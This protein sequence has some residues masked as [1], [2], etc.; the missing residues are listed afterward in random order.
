MYSGA[1]V[2]P[3]TVTYQDVEY[4]VSGFDQTDGL[5]PFV[6]N[7]FI[8]SLDLQ[9]HVDTLRRMQFMGC[10]QLASLSLP[11]TLRYIEDECFQATEVLEGSAEE[12]LLYGGVLKVELFERLQGGE[13]RQVVVVKASRNGE[14]LHGVSIRCGFQKRCLQLSRLYHIDLTFLH[15]LRTL[16]CLSLYI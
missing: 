6:G 5:S 10:T 3:A 14:R 8:T 4:V 11:S 7:P 13:I 12:S 9:L 16:V 1:I 15:K 2:I